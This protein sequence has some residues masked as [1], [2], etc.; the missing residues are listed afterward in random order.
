MSKAKHLFKERD[1]SRPYVQSVN[2]AMTADQPAPT[3]PYNGVPAPYAGVFP[4]QE[5]CD[6]VNSLKDK[7]FKFFDDGIRLVYGRGSRIIEVD[8]MEAVHPIEYPPQ[9][10]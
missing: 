1:Y 8:N 5:L 4:S 3:T 6:Y 7:H 9:G 2:T 10:F